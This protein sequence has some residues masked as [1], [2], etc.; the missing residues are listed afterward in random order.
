[1]AKTNQIEILI[2][3]AVK[4]QQSIN[5]LNSDLKGFERNAQSAGKSAGVSSNAIAMGF[6]KAQL[7]IGAFN[8]AVNMTV[9]AVK[10]VANEAMNMVE[11]ASDMERQFTTL[12]ILADK[13]NLDG[14]KAVEVATLLGRELNIGIGNS[15]ESLQKLL[16]SGL[17]IEQ[18]TELMRRFTNEAITGKQGTM[19][20]GEAV[21]NLASGY[22]ME[23]S[24]IMDRA[25]ISENISALLEK[26]AKLRG[27]E[28]A[29]LDEASRAQL[30]YDAF[31]RL[32]NQT[33]GA[34]EQL[35][36]NYIVKKTKLSQATEELGMKMGEILKPLGDF[37]LGLV[38]L[39]NQAIDKIVTG[40]IDLYNGNED[41]R[42]AID[43]VIG[44]LERFGVVI[45]E[46][47]IKWVEGFIESLGRN[48]DELKIISDLLAG[49]DG[50]IDELVRLTDQFGLSKEG[51]ESF[52]EGL[53]KGV[54]NTLALIE[55]LLELIRTVKQIKTKWENFFETMET[56]QTLGLNKLVDG[57]FKL[58][59]DSATG[60]SKGIQAG[61]PQVNQSV[62]NMSSVALNSAKT[63]LESHSPSLAFM[64]IGADVTQGFINGLDSGVGSIMDTVGNI[65][66]NFKAGF[67]GGTTDIIAQFS[68]VYATQLNE[69]VQLSGKIQELQNIKKP[70]D[71]INEQIKELQKLRDQKEAEYEAE[72]AINELQIQN[73][74]DEI[75]RR[76][77]QAQ[78]EAD[79]K[80][81][82]FR[83][84]EDQKKRYAIEVEKELQRE[85]EQIQKDSNDKKLNS[86]KKFAGDSKDILSKVF[87]GFNIN[88]TAF[89][90]KLNSLGLSI[91][92]QKSGKPPAWSTERFIPE[93]SMVDKVAELV[94]QIGG[95]GN[96]AQLRYNK[97]LTELGV[98][99]DDQKGIM[100]FVRDVIRHSNFQDKRDTQ[101]DLDKA[102]VMKDLEYLSNQNIAQAQQAGATASSSSGF[103]PSVTRIIRFENLF[104]NVSFDPT[105][106]VE[107]LTNKIMDSLIRKIELNI[108]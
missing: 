84:S 16:K 8:T 69:I 52:A 46:R 55:A 7:A 48:S 39:K 38:S 107:E 2:D 35:E 60:F 100:N 23:M 98:A 97:K 65:L 47:V 26:E 102:Q 21:N 19:S 54:E 41:V 87:E 76:K 88:G 49:D 81:R 33:L 1:M 24:A 11:S 4:N 14:K 75:E 82:M 50:V 70:S 104:G 51:G 30:K 56:I 90:D 43:N 22:Q 74:K 13:F 31:I 53:L 34:S 3:L 101:S 44:K 79:E 71:A 20:L 9:G 95:I 68:G 72:K 92:K 5:K 66:T 77:L 6:A 91:G 15:A 10:A 106:N 89:T 32:T 108:R 17:N 62:Q 57:F 93:R 96:I 83:G 58:G 67:L 105:T 78:Y 99:T 37:E 18:A 28:L 45:S 27:V 73:T 63:K 61:T 64:K 29:S 103:V 40:L 86:I 94:A 80:L 36:D 59:N 25:G 12:T 85:L 42:F